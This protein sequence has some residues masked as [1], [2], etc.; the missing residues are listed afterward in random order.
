MTRTMRIARNRIGI[1]HSM[2]MK[3]RHSSFIPYEVPLHEEGGK[4]CAPDGRFC[5]TSSSNHPFDNSVNLNVLSARDKALRESSPILVLVIFLLSISVFVFAVFL[6]WARIRKISLTNESDPIVDTL[7]PTHPQK[8]RGIPGDS[9]ASSVFDYSIAI[10]KVRGNDRCHSGPEFVICCDSD[11]ADSERS[12]LDRHE[13][14]EPVRIELSEVHVKSS[15][16]RMNSV[17]STE[18]SSE[19]AIEARISKEDDENQ[20]Q[21]PSDGIEK[22]EKSGRFMY[23]PQNIGLRSLAMKQLRSRQAKRRLAMHSQIS[24]GTA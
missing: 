21:P 22:I 4:I 19:N 15:L 13:Y 2:N 7:N 14:D 20:E 3:L 10:P 11:S 16:E 24:H 1:E 5:M 23:D 9:R 18:V 17:H 8:A 6:V 12:E